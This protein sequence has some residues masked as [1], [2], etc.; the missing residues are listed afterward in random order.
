MQNK[1]PFAISLPSLEPMESLQS[2]IAYVSKHYKESDQKMVDMK[3]DTYED[4][5]L[6]LRKIGERI[7]TR[8]QSVNNQHLDLDVFAAEM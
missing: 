8:G 7:N 4:E 3:P 2:Y 1:Q 6:N 5:A